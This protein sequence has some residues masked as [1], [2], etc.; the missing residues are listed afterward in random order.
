M[1]FYLELFLSRSDCSCYGNSSGWYCIVSG[2]QIVLV[3]SETVLVLVI[4]SSLQRVYIRSAH[5]YLRMQLS[6]SR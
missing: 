5:D 3:L 2:L 4:E 6:C 1:C